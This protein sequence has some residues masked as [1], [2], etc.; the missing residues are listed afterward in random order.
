ML[1]RDELRGGPCSPT[2]QSSTKPRGESAF[3]SWASLA[4]ALAWHPAGNAAPRGAT[5]ASAA[6]ETARA[7]RGTNKHAASCFAC[8]FLC[9][10]RHSTSALAS[11]LASHQKARKSISLPSMP[12]K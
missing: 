5:L 12:N 9:V 11:A 8:A 10:A 3:A 7:L 2:H 6:M 4:E 1:V